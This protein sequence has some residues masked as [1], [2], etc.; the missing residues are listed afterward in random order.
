MEWSVFVEYR[1]IASK[2]YVEEQIKANPGIVSDKLT[3][4]ALAEHLG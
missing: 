4:R 3:E 2:T 1:D